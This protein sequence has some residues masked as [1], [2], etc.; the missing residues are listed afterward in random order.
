MCQVI[1]GGS[2]E[3]VVWEPRVEVGDVCVA[4]PWSGGGDLGSGSAPAGMP[5]LPTLAS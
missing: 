3:C 2:W 5:G 4:E 1:G